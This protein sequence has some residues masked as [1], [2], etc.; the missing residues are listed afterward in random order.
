MKTDP[1]AACANI[2]EHL[3]WAL[4]HDVLAHPL[5]ALTLYRRWAVRFHDW[6][7][8]RAWPRMTASPGAFFVLDSRHGPVR[9]RQ[10]MAGFYSATCPFLKAHKVVVY[11]D[12]PLEALEMACTWFDS[13]FEF[14]AEQRRNAGI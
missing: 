5:M 11:A 3:G 4:A 14:Q 13:Y 2:K 10:E 8:K 7:S 6:T 1:R 12:D 9:M